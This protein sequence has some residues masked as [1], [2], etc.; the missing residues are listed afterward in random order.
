PVQPER[1]ADLF[2]LVDK[3]VQVPQRRFV[4][5]VAKTRTELVVVVVLD[6]RA[7]QVAVAR[8]QVLVR[9]ARPAV[10]EQHPQPR[11]VAGPLDPHSVRPLRRIDAD[12]PGTAAQHVLP[13]GV[14][15]V[16][17]HDAPPKIGSATRLDYASTPRIEP[18]QAEPRLP[19]P[20]GEPLPHPG[21]HQIL[22]VCTG[23]RWTR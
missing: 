12:H 8:F 6:P 7:G 17:A 4:R 20:S 16:P 1:L 5:L 10:Q 21:L 15:Q 22:G 11:V 23:R 14:V 9:R 13:A 2:Y 18:G 19:R 3:A